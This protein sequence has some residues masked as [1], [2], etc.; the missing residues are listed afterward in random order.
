MSQASLAE[1][2]EAVTTKTASENQDQ[3]LNQ[4]SFQQLEKMQI[5]FGQAKLGQ[6]F[7]QV[8]TDD[9]RYCQWF[10]SR[11]SESKKPE[12]RAFVRFLSLWVERQELEK[13][14][15][16]TPSSKSMPK[17]KAKCRAAAQDHVGSVID[18]EEEEDMWDTVTESP[19]MIAPLLENQ[20]AQRIDNMEMMLGQIM[21]QLHTLTCQIALVSQ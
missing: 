9:G 12:H 7:K 6:T 17:A 14:A 8:V 19:Q 16:P 15:A 1:R 21:S 20:N 3:E 4:K 10:L 2:S 11:F 18:L 13:N 5:C